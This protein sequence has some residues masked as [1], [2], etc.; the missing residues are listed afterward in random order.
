MITNLEAY[1]KINTINSISTFPPI[2]I[3]NQFID[4]YS[5]LLNLSIKGDYI[6]LSYQFL[7][8]KY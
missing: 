5:E 2:F 7:I 6:K 4:G 3:N 8:S 1:N